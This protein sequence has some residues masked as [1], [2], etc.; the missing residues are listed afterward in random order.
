MKRTAAILSAA[1]AILSCGNHNT[2]EEELRTPSPEGF[3]TE[4]YI[5]VQD[6]VNPGETFSGLMGRLGMNSADAYTLVGLCDSIFNVRKL[7]AGNQIDAYYS[8]DSLSTRLEYAVYRQSK[9]R[10]VVFQTGDSLAVWTYDRPVTRE[11]R[12]TDVTI[13]TSLWN[14]LVESGA[15]P[16]LIMELADIFQWTV[17]FFGMQEGDRFRVIYDQSLC[18]GEVVSIDTV[19]IAVFSRGD[20][21]IPAVRFDIGKG[22]T[23]WGKN[24]ESLK[25]MFLKAPLRYNRISSRFTY[26]RRHPITGKVRPHTAVDYAAPTGTPVHAIGEGRVTLCG[27]D[28]HGG[29]NRIKIKHPQ[30]YESCYMHLSRFAKGI[31]S[32]SLVHQG[33]LIGYV[34]STGSSTGP[35]LDFRIWHNGKPLDP[36]SLNSPNKDPLE[37]KYL[38]EFNAVY[39][40]YMNELNA[41]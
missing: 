1:L 21:E 27:W 20:V 35:H 28:S 18:E 5:K 17:N 38:D 23:Y 13:R 12:K 40:K 25:K 34:G 6:A 4:D 11:H 36:L 16:S 39:E 19:H 8:G 29:G 7:R 33:D 32:G 30:G 14:D 10:S 31:R 41:E 9:V 26:H 15:S 37:K 3:Y 22:N 24:G 2:V